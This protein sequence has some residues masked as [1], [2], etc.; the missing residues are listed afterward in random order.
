MIPSKIRKRLNIK[1]G[2]RLYIEERDDEL[3]L[4]TVTLAYFNKIA[5][6]LPTK[7]K[8]A[9]ALVENHKKDLKREA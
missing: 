1:K 6:C 4:K 9:A 3:I 8:L 2:T 7:G 5:G